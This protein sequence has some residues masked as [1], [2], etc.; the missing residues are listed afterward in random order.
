MALRLG[1][2]NKRQVYL[3]IAIFALIAV[4]G[5]WELFGSFGGSPKPPR[6]IPAQAASPAVNIHPAVGTQSASASGNGQDQPAG[7]AQK[8]TNAGLDPTL[9][10]DKLAMSE[11]VEYEGTGRNIFSAESVLVQPIEA[12]V[13]SARN[14]EPAVTAALVANEK[15]HPPAIDLKYFGYAQSKDK[16]LKAFFVHGEDTFMAKTGEIVDHRYKVGAISQGSVQVT[17]LG[18]NNTQTLPLTTN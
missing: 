4:I 16:S 9:H 3:V 8:L 7:E 5:G 18:Y 1:T 10:F 6:P 13:K 15:P 2:E 17:D 14:G 11:E 12:P